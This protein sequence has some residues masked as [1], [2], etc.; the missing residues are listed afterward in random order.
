MTHRQKGCLRNCGVHC[1]QVLGCEECGPR[2]DFSK[3]LLDHTKVYGLYCEGQ[4]EMLM[5]REIDR[6]LPMINELFN[7][8]KFKESLDKESTDVKL[9]FTVKWDKNYFVISLF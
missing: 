6:N 1:A 4:K 5:I 7:C 8:D 2:T 9:D 3:V